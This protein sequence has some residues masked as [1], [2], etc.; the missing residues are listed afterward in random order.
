[1]RSA[2]PSAIPTDAQAVPEASAE[3]AAYLF[4]EVTRGRTEHP[5]RPVQTARF[6]IGSSARCD[7]RLGGHNVPPLVALIVADHTDAWLDAFAPSPLIRVNGRTQTSARLQDGDCIQIDSFE[8][9]VHRPTGPG[10]AATE[11]Q[12][13]AATGQIDLRAPADELPVSELSASELVNR[14]EAATELVDEFERRQRLGVE[15]LLS[16]LEERLAAEPTEGG[17]AL[18]PI[19]D[20]AGEAEGRDAAELESLVAQL[21]AIVSEL[22]SRYGLQSRREAGFRDAVSTL[23]ETQ[24]R[25]SRQLELLLR[26]VTSLKAEAAPREPNRAIAS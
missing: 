20:V 16:A 21:S 6:L 23:F 3:P 18:F 19:P 26:R 12:P 15:A 8:F 17:E 14:I 7:L 9:V 11:S 13:V 4:L 10:E 1:L 5:L 25:L 24:D 2:D 22:E